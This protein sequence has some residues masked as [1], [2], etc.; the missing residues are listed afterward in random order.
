MIDTHCH[1]LPDVD[2]GPRTMEGA[3]RMAE[4]AVKQGIHTM[5]ATPH[6]ATKRYSTPASTIQRSVHKFNERLKK[7]G[8]PLTVLP[9]QEFR[10][11]NE[12]RTEHRKGR[13]QTLAG[14]PYL[15][16]ELPSKAIPPYLF[17][18]VSYMA[19]HQLRILIAHPERNVGVIQQ[20]E[21]LRSWL[22]HGILLQVTTQSLI[23]YFGRKVQETAKWICRRQYAHLIASDA[24]DVIQ[25]KFYFREGYKM[26]EELRHSSYT[27]ALQANASR[28][29][30][31]EE[32]VSLYDDSVRERTEE[33]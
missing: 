25:R 9:G 24:H 26:V 23:G 17:E 22:E 16:V 8:I 19:R 3:I 21:I 13:I 7:Q 31:G 15:L 11:T 29:I 1:I 5:I 32:I 30:R 28:L 10:L 6:H 12:Y 2:D 14:S 33:I 4:A 27:A 20:P 18:F